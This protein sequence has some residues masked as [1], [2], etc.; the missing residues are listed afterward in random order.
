LEGIYRDHPDYAANAHRAAPIAVDDDSPSGHGMHTFSEIF[1]DGTNDPLKQAR[2]LL[3]N[4]QGFYTNNQALS[5]GAG[6]HA[7]GS[8]YELV[9]RLIDDHEVMFQTASWGHGRTTQYTA[10]SVEMD[11]I[12]FDHDI[13]I[14]QSQSNAGDQMSR[15]QAWAKNVIA[16]GGVYHFD[17]S[18]P[19]DDKWNSGTS[20]AS[21][22]PASDGR[23]K[24]DLCAYYDLIRTASGAS[25]YIPNF[26]GTSGATPIVAGHAGLCIE[27]WT[28]GI[29]GNELPQP[30]GSRFANRPHFTTTK[31][32]LI[33]SA[34][35]YD[36][37]GSGHDLARSHQGWGFPDV[38]RLYDLSSKCFAVNEDDVLENL[39][40]KKYSLSVSAGEPLLKITMVYADPPGTPLSAGPHRVNNLDLKVT[41][42]TGVVYWGNHG[43]WD[44]RFSVPGG[45]PNM[46]D[47]VENVF[48]ENPAAGKWT[49]EVIADELVEDAH[50][51]TPG[52]IDADY[53]LVALGVRTDQPPRYAYTGRQGQHHL[54]GDTG[55][56]LYFWHGDRWLVNLVYEK[57]DTHY[58]YYSE[59]EYPRYWWAFA[60]KSYVCGRY[61]VWFRPGSEAGGKWVYYQRACRI[62]PI[63][64]DTNKAAPRR[65]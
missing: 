28:N 31:A 57:G 11:E 59:K 47:T 5:G 18:D 37:A 30:G 61:S 35:Q 20:Q 46:V 58:W 49:V 15:P 2:G 40:G 17:N 64:T 36:F 32:L 3:P 26:G 42:P 55:T 38:K 25:G 54:A 22:G 52:T 16:V 9:G 33:C 23:V 24:P 63:N 8:R 14:T 21:T 4:A 27:M 44:G 39:E 12:I 48:V 62:R 7:P 60:K 19:N 10:R 50:R 43:L 53:A 65:R 34:R 45:G 41:D 6:S 29:F 1:G 51:E 56:G 13:P